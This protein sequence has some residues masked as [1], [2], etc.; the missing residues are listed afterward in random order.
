MECNVREELVRVK[1][2]GMLVEMPRSQYEEYKQQVNRENKQSSLQ[3][4]EYS[5]GLGMLGDSIRV[6][7]QQ[8]LQSN[9][10]EVKQY[11]QKAAEYLSEKYNS[12]EDLLIDTNTVS[13]VVRDLDIA[14]QLDDSLVGV[15]EGVKSAIKTATMTNQE[16]EYQNEQARSWSKPT[17]NTLNGRIEEGIDT[18]TGKKYRK[19]TTTGE[20]TTDFDEFAD[21]VER[22]ALEQNIAQQDSGVE[23]PEFVNNLQVK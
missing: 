1:M 14:S 17:D 19:D 4:S 8:A 21:R 20:F 13:Q 2:D 12:I 3:D 23:A 5:V 15:V 18:M 7:I 6:S 16:I 11:A 9:N 22:V 10:P